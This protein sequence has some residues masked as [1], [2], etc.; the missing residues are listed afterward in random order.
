MTRT[1]RK[2]RMG[3]VGGG[4]G[5][6]I[7]A[8]HRMAAT[9]DGQIELVCG[10]FSSN[11]EKSRESGADWYL[12]HDRCYG[13]YMEMLEKESAMPSEQRM[14]FVTVVTPN[15]LHYPV[16]AAALDWKFHVVCDKPM[17]F[18]LREAAALER[19]VGK[20]GQLFALTYNYSGYPMVREARSRIRSGELGKIRKVVVEYPQGWL[21]KALEKTGQKQADWR[22][23]PKRAGSSG[24]LG[25]IGT[26]AA[27]L[28]EFVSGLEIE[29]VF[30][31]L[32]TFVRG[33]KLDDDGSVLLRF[34]GGAKGVLLASQISTG[35]EN[36]L[37]IRLYGEKG[38]LD[39]RQEEPNTLVMKWP[40][41]PA[42]IVRAAGPGLSGA[43][44]AACRLPSGH[45]EG[46]LEAFATIYRDFAHTL[47]RKLAGEKV[48]ANT[49]AFPSV[50]DGVR[51]MAFIEAAVA[52][53]KAGK[54][55]KLST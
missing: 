17:T 20:S 24:C 8:V 26:H 30:A 48:P 40:D 14:D 7:G 53:A 22:T 2:L 41:R 35:E 37:R 55:K 5:A 38:G 33:R 45:P 25:D 31:E 19:K 10:A 43:A 32:T 13:S 1:K 21:S 36:G 34:K 46:F 4:R 12:P 3:M 42:E 28:A 6:F 52:S 23:D 49:R 47:Q 39:W 51:G 54:W 18:N 15:H 27:H 16:A 44:A 9:L 50:R 11:P 29:E